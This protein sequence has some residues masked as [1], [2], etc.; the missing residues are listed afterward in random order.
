MTPP[1][2]KRQTKITSFITIFRLLEIFLLFLY[3]LILSMAVHVP[4]FQNVV[5]LFFVGQLDF[6]ILASKNRLFLNVYATK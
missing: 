1:I 4:C 6:C 3:H 2:L 5:Y